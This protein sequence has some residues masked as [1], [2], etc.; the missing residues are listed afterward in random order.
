[1]NLLN[2]FLSP[3]DSKD[4]RM[5]KEKTKNSHC[6]S[7]SLMGE[8]AGP[9]IFPEDAHDPVIIPWWLNSYLF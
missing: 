1:M 8:D 5:S 3:G 7:W 2:H 9:G 6:L 4:H